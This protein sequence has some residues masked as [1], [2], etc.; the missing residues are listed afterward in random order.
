MNSLLKPPLTF[1]LPLLL[2]VSRA[3]LSP[4]QRLP[5]KI[6]D[7]SARH[8]ELFYESGIVPDGTEMTAYAFQGITKKWV[9]LLLWTHAITRILKSCIPHVIPRVVDSSH[10]TWTRVATRVTIFLTCDLT[11]YMPEWLATWLVLT[12][13]TK[14]LR[15]DLYSRQNTCDLTKSWTWS[16]WLASFFKSHNYV[17]ILRI[18][19]AAKRAQA[20]ALA[21]IRKQTWS[22]SQ[23]QLMLVR[24]RRGTA[25]TTS[26]ARVGVGVGGGGQLGVMPPNNAFS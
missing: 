5:T 14:Y 9:F 12:C 15:L 17:N 10:A 24:A 13:T 26:V 4:S 7:E 19:S 16:K 21:C 18:E 20:P 25:C 23:I 22:R 6:F 8:P 11:C 3:K 1:F 2:L